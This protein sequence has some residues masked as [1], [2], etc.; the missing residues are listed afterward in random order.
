[1]PDPTSVC[2][3][4]VQILAAHDISKVSIIAH[5]WGTFLAGWV[6]KMRPDIVSHLTLI[7]P[8]AMNVVLFETTYAIIYKPPVD[9]SGYLLYYFVRKDISVSNAIHR[10]F[11]W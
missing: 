11:F 10:N 9:I 3:S 2:N 6:V 4:I 5:S 1:V 7:E 8:V